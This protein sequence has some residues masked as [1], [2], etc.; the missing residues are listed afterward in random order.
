MD[1]VP[2]RNIVEAHAK[3]VVDGDMD[4][5]AA[6]F[7]PDL[8]NSVNDLAQRLPQPTTDADVEKFEMSDDHADV[9]IRYSNDDTNL[10]IRTRWEEVDGR[11]MIV[12]AAPVED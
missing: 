9:R 6:D 5:A 12:D 7:A 8:R 11:P 4:T 3:A 2:T 10:A 1:E